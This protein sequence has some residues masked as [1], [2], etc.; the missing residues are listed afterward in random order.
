MSILRHLVPFGMAALLCG[1][2]GSNSHLLSVAKDSQAAKETAEAGN[3]LFDMHQQGKLPG[4]TKDMHGEMTSDM[5]PFSEVQSNQEVYPISRTFHVAIT[6][7]SFTNNY[8]LVKP[9]KASSWQLK[10]AWR[11]DSESHITVWPLK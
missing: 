11:I 9:S 7:E 3:V 8:T 4:D 6:G 2:L 10:Q 5:I 1:C